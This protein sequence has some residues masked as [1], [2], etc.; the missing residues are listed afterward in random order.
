M[1][2]CIYIYIHII[3]I[4]IY[5]YIY[6]YRSIYVCMYIYIYIYYTQFVLETS[7]RFDLRFPSERQPRSCSSRKP[8]KTNDGNH[9]T[10]VPCHVGNHKQTNYG[11]HRNTF[12]ATTE[13]IKQPSLWMEEIAAGADPAAEHLAHFMRPGAAAKDH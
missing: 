7:W 3:C 1:N 12:L 10:N 2:M 13:T 4:Y 6:I 11:N 5:I 8:C 9:T